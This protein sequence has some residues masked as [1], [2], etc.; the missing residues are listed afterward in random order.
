[1]EREFIKYWEITCGSSQVDVYAFGTYGDACYL[2]I[3]DD[4]PTLALCR[5][6]EEAENANRSKIVR[7]RDNRGV[8]GNEYPDARAVVE[9]LLENKLIAVDTAKY[10]GPEYDPNAPNGVEEAELGF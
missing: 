6:L 1:M 4:A 5:E 9:Y 2:G 7:F 3:K 8:F 10:V